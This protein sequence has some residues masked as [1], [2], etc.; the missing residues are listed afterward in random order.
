MIRKLPWLAAAL[1]LAAHCGFYSFSGSSLPS[2]L[3][4]V[5][6][7]VFGNQSLESDV[8]DAT[9]SA[10]STAIVTGNLLK[11][12]QHDGNSTITGNIT[13]YTNVPYTFSA[14]DTRQVSVQQYVVRI[15]ASIEFT[16]NKKNKEI[17]KGTLTGEG[18]YNLQTESEQTGKT[19]AITQLVTLIIQNSVQGW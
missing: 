1:L 5:E 3:K 18:V 11:I 15:T 8:A 4:T 9:T 6:I 14:S 19:R 10:L 2:D 12:V 16:N 17:Y 7:P 13:S